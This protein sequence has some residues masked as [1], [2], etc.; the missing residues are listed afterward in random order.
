MAYTIMLLF[1]TFWLQA[2]LGTLWTVAKFPPQHR[3]SQDT[4]LIFSDCQRL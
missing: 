1:K 4:Q 3:I 2:K